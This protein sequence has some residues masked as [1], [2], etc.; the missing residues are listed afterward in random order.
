MTKPSPLGIQR[1]VMYSD[2]QGIS[3]AKPLRL[4]PILGPT[5]A[6]IR[7][8]QEAKMATPKSVGGSKTRK[9]NSKTPK[10][11]RKHISMPP[12]I[13]DILRRHYNITPETYDAVKQFNS[14]KDERRLQASR[15]IIDRTIIE[16]REPPDVRLA[17][18][19]EESESLLRGYATLDTQHRAEVKRLVQRITAYLRD[20]SRKRP[21]NAL[22]LASPGAGKSHFIKQLAGT[23]KE[24]RVQA[25]TFNMATMQSADDMA[26]PIDELRNL[27]VNDRFPLLF[28]DEFDS[29]P[30]RYAS[31]LPLLWDGELHIGHRDLK[32][33]KAV[34][35]LAGSSPELPKAMDQ[36]AKMRL[37]VDDLD[38]IA[39]KGKLVDLLSR[40][41]GGVIEIPDLDLRT[42]N[43]DRRVDKSCVA[44]ALL[45]NRF[46]ADLQLI[47]RP[48]LRFIAHTSFRY[49]VR[50]V[51]HLV[52]VID[53]KALRK[54]VLNTN[55]LGL[56]LTSEEALQDSSLKLHLLDKDQA[57]GVV[58]RWKSFSEDRTV[59]DLQ[60]RRIP[61]L[62]W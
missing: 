15:D 35:V 54:K 47:P 26:Q 46:G 42:E 61:Y 21:F 29:D 16:A 53:N 25:V 17:L 44:V 33:G 19:V 9:P 27:K 56:P 39:P 37:E 55:R 2:V 14:L 38:D 28:L 41:N 24:D 36:S 43:R 31:L 20:T 5:R 49:G 10:K 40:I 62:E 45:R 18:A 58:N 3:I 1:E 32:L 52:D 7:F 23:M 8:G 4:S 34:I 13:A 11:R 59:V 6:L 51:A 30:S 48:L 60:R 22:M 57:F 50:S 12:H